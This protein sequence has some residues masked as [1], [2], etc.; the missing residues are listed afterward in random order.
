[1]RQKAGKGLQYIG[2]INTETGKPTY[3]EGFTGLFVFSMDTSVSTAYLRINSLK[4]E[5]TA[6][7]FCAR[8]SVKTTC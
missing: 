4:T 7:C 6:M 8:N 5:D 1:V 3:T 2:W